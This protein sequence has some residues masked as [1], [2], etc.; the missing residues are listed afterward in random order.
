M[1][2]N[3]DIDEAINQA[4]VRVWR[5]GRSFD[6]ERGSLAAW[7][8]VVARNCARRILESRVRLRAEPLPASLTA[9]RVAQPDAG[10]GSAAGAGS[11]H[12][13]D[14]QP[15]WEIDLYNC[16]DALPPQQRAVMLL[17][18]AAGG[19]AIGSE[20]A[21]ELGTSVNSVYVSRANGRRAVRLA[22]EALGH[23]VCG[24]AGDRE[25]IGTPQPDALA[26]TPESAGPGQGRPRQDKPGLA[27]TGQAKQMG[28]GQ[29]RAGGLEA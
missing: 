28:S 4:T 27:R 9:D 19:N 29:E 13:H 23:R 10:T 8:F 18:L 17:D 26:K 25:R 6:Q 14:A 1:L 20:V 15:Q 3:L 12:A 5:S 7:F 22:M 2:D 16:I 24:Q 21:R 11:R